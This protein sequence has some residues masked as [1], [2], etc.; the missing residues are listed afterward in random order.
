MVSSE[1][2]SNK[3]YDWSNAADNSALHNRNFSMPGYFLM[4]PTPK[5]LPTSNFL[6]NS[7][8]IQGS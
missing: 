6:D 5:I 2:F 3:Y 8:Y 7:V 4:H 1:I